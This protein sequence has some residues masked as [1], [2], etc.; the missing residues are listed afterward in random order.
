MSKIESFDLLCP[1]CNFKSNYEVNLDL[2]FNNVLCSNC[3]QNLKA[4]IAKARSRNS[5]QIKA[6]GKD[7]F[8]KLEERK[9]SIRVKSF[10]GEEDLIEFANNGRENFEF[11]S[12][13]VVGFTYWRDRIMLVQNF[14][15]NRE[16]KISPAPKWM[17][18]IAYFIKMIPALIIMAFLIFIFILCKF[19][20]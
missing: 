9:F 14:T 4:R 2:T 1:Y 3:G 20:S 10:N 5:R 17:N 12:G 16:M 7:D 15:I 8:F 11:R 13:D 18:N 19:S 6:S